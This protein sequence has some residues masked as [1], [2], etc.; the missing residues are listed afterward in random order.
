MATLTEWPLPLSNNFGFYLRFLTPEKDGTVFYTKYIADKIGELN[1]KKNT[2]REW[3]IPWHAKPN[4]NPQG[5]IYGPDKAI[6]FALQMAQAVVRFDPDTSAFTSYGVAGFPF[7]LA[8]DS[9][10]NLWYTAIRGIFGSVGIIGRLDPNAPTSEYWR[11]PPKV[12][13]SPM[14]IWVDSHDNVWFTNDDANVGHPGAAFA[15][16]FKNKLSYWI[17]PPGI[18]SV[19][20]GI[21]VDP[22]A[23]NVWVTKWYPDDR[24]SFIVYKY[25]IHGN[26]CLA[27]PNPPSQPFRSNPYQIRLDSHNN[28]WYADT[29]GG[30]GFIRNDAECGEVKLKSGST[31]LDSQ[32]MPVHVARG[33]SAPV[34]TPSDPKVT[35]IKSTPIACYE[36]FVLPYGNT[37]PT[38]SLALAHNQPGKVYFG[39]AG[40]KSN[41]I[42][43]LTV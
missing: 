19:Y 34:R 25:D 3:A 26:H 37:S 2:V 16:L 15:R 20:R 6:W 28:A 33:G 21:V 36:E 27:Y 40:S 12:I 4:G 39:E 18:Q 32:P 42:G 43:L 9:Q 14:E 22:Q 38:G 7:Q 41:L 29:S 17:V 5:I 24:G 13:L 30:I 31:S 1:V 11:L 23:E 35:R 10:G 8:F